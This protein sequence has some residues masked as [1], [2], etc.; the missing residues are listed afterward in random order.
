MC[1]NIPCLHK[2]KKCLLSQSDHFHTMF[3]L[4]ILL[5]AKKKRETGGW[6]VISEN[7]SKR[8]KQGVRKF[9]KV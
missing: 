8:N 3:Q 5:S 2:G 6:G 7:S 1:A 4:S 9:L